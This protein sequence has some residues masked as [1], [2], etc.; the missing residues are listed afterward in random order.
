MTRNGRKGEGGKGRGSISLLIS[1]SPLLPLSLS[2]I[3]SL[4]PFSL[5]FPQRMWKTLWKS[6]FL[7][8]QVPE[9]FGL[10]AFC[11]RW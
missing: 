3:F 11:T 2:F 4:L 8:L 5:F 9:F 1:P 7:R 10:L 6:G